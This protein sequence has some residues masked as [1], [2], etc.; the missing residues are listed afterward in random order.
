MPLSIQG[1]LRVLAKKKEDLPKT[2]LRQIREAP[3]DSLKNEVYL[4]GESAADGSRG[5]L[6]FCPVVL[7]SH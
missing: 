7:Y 6:R 5:L 3:A 2:I 1:K 4:A